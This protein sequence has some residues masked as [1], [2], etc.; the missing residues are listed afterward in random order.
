MTLVPNLLASGLL[1]ILVSLGLILWSVL[2]PHRR[3]SGPVLL[4]LSVLLLLV[5][6]GFGPPLL[7][8]ILAAFATLGLDIFAALAR[9]RKKG[10]AFRHP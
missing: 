6:G 1:T 5:G 3:G 9:D 8:S 2:F 7:G 4:G 10:S